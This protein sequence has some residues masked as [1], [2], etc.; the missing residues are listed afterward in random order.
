MEESKKEYSSDD[1]KT[2]TIEEWC[3]LRIFDN[4]EIDLI[5][6]VI[7]FLQEYMGGYRENEDVVD[8]FFVNELE[9]AE[10]FKGICEAYIRSIG[11]ESDV[12]FNQTEEGFSVVHSRIICSKLAQHYQKEHPDHSLSN[13]R[14]ED[15]LFALPEQVKKKFGGFF[16][17]HQ[18]S[19]LIGAFIRNEIVLDNNRVVVFAN[20]GHKAQLTIDFIKNFNAFG[21]SGSDN[22]AVKYYFNVPYATHIILSN[23]NPFWKAVD[24]FIAG[25]EQT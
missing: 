3:Q 7:G 12:V 24:A 13:L 6:V 20:A 17:F 14:K 23:D 22:L 1:I 19:F 8:G 25:L 21:A 11:K 5:Y 2:L 16:N 4:A 15:D 9:K 10:L 18:Y